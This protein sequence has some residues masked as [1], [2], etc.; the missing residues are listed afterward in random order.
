MEED[1]TV[2]GPA[3]ILLAWTMEGKIYA[4]SARTM[5]HTAVNHENIT[6]W[7]TLPSHAASHVRS[8]DTDFR[9]E[10]WNTPR[11][12]FEKLQNQ[13]IRNWSTR[14]VFSILSLERSIKC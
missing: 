10:K 8:S 5:L 1:L 6:D 11:D 14:G 12:V 4:V 9:K 2:V 3:D 7:K 13:L